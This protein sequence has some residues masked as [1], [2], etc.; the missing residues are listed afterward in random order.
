MPL[1][2]PLSETI[3][4][5]L[6]WSPEFCKDFAAQIKPE[7]FHVEPFRDM[8]EAAKEHY[9]AYGKPAGSSSRRARANHYQAP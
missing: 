8:A 9:D 5:A 7:M 1:E 4:A 6:V 3:L 2:G